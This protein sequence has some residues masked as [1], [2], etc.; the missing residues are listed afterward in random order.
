MINQW[1]VHHSGSPFTVLIVKKQDE[2]WRL[3][4]DYHQLNKANMKQHFTIPIIE[5]L[6]DIVQGTC[7]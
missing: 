1:I 6:L 4:V 7:F 3:C 2:R 5:E